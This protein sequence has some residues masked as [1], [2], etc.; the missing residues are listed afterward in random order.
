MKKLTAKKPPSRKPS[1]RAKSNPIERMDSRG[2]KYHVEDH[3]LRYDEMGLSA[4]TIQIENW[5]RVI[6]G[7][8]SVSRV[9]NR[10]VGAI[11]EDLVAALKMTPFPSRATAT[12]ES[13]WTAN[14]LYDQ[15]EGFSILHGVSSRDEFPHYRWIAC[16]PVVGG[17][18]GWRTMV[19]V[20]EPKKHEMIKVFTGKTF[21]REAAFACANRCAFLLG[22]V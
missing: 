10:S 5:H 22:A 8:G 2:E 11:F 21:D 12:L 16:F 17:N 13:G 20:V 1:R 9:S 19:C 7:Q 4:H 15:F 14:S 6:G 18:E 3:P